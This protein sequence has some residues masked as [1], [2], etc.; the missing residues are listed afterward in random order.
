M[1]MCFLMGLWQETDRKVASSYIYI[2][3]YII[4]KITFFLDMTPYGQ[5]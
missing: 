5:I 2:Y 1:I 3:I 4:L